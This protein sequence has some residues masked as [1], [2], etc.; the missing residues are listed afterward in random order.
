MVTAV[1]LARRVGN[2]PADL[3]SFVGRRRELDEIRQMQT[4]SRL[5]TLTGVGGVGKTRLALRA[6]AEQQRA[7]DAIWLVDLSTLDD[8]E[9]VAE[10]VAATMGVGDQSEPSPLGTL[11]KALSAQRTLIVLDNCEHLRDACAS[12][13]ERLLRAVPDLRI[14][15]TSRQ[16]L[17]IMG[18]RQMKVA[19][20][21]LPEPDRAPSRALELYDGVRLFLERAASVVP[22]FRLTPDN[23]DAV[24]ELCRRLDGIPLAIELAAVRLRA[25]SVNALVERLDDRY[26]VL[27]SGSPT[28]APRQRTLHALVEWS[29]RLLSPAERTLWSRL[30]IFPGHFDLEAVEAVCTGDG[31]EREDVLDLI[32][33]LLD[34]S[35]LVREEHE[36]RVRYRMLETLR[37][38]CGHRLGGPDERRSLA[39]RHRDHYLRL[40]ERAVAEW[41]GPAQAIWFTRLRLERAHLRAAMEFSLDEPGETEAGLRMA[42]LLFDPHWIPNAFYSEGRYWLDRLLR[43]APQPTA[44]RAEALCTDAHLAL[45]QN[46]RMVGELLVGE[47]RALAE[48]LGD[49]R[50]LAFASLVSGIG[51]HQ[52]GDNARAVV[53]LEEAVEGLTPA[54]NVINVVTGLFALAASVDCLGDSDR[55]GRLFERSLALAE[56]HGESWIR[57]WVLTTF[58]VHEWQR[59]NNARATWLARESLRVGRGFGDRLALGTAL[60]TLGWI[61]H[62]EGR[63]AAAA[64]M[65]GAAEGVCR[66]AGVTVLWME[67]QRE[68]HER[69]VSALRAKMGDHAF[70]RALRQG[71]R[72]TLDD[73]IAEALGEQLD[74]GGTVD[75]DERR[76]PAEPEPSPLTPR[77]REIA[78]LIAQGLSN[79]EI[80]SALVISQRTAEGHVERILNKLAF[81]SR[82]QIAAWVTAR[83]AGAES[84][85]DHD[86]PPPPSRPR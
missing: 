7:V 85:Q 84:R 29:Y 77:E 22:G 27:K 17:G 71:E 39:R 8:P 52:R 78:E 32:D 61:L 64:R 40:V 21:A 41:F 50:I 51:A 62:R 73:A 56:S 79:R 74:K 55:A 46:N 68:F 28:A 23:S 53:L 16:S 36:G 6:A 43:V 83:K 63:H 5:V 69:C 60:E 66:V 37:E 76:E 33:V 19:P 72:L 26:G 15:A 2:L 1:S 4:V 38:F 48:K 70:D 57:S 59:G 67:H 58:A 49:T 12:L 10:T 65:L 75:R 35:L 86:N 81:N 82:T 13:V 44:V 20:L 30:S 34:K 14:I 42:T 31:I 47:G 24:V 9:L 80:S 45:M 25:L 11:I 54:G 3:T 18:E